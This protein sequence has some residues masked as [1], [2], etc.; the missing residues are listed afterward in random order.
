MTTSTLHHIANVALPIW[1][2]SAAWELRRMCLRDS[3]RS[4]ASLVYIAGRHFCRRMARRGCTDPRPKTLDA[5]IEAN[6]RQH[7][8]PRHWSENPTD[9]A[10]RSS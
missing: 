6:R 5:V 7:R 4:C 8:G 10:I 9:E 3:D 1:R 2:D